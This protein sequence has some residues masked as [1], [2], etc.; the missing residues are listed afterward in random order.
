MLVGWYVL[1]FYT[2]VCCVL[3]AVYVVCLLCVF[4]SMFVCMDSL[5]CTQIVHTV[6]NLPIQVPQWMIR[7]HMDYLSQ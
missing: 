3:W 2:G 6:I 5:L 4:V 7:S 1:K